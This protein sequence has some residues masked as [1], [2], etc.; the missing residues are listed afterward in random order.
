MLKVRH[1][2]DPILSKPAKPV[3]K[4]DAELLGLIKDMFETMYEEHG[5][6]LAAPQIGESLRLCVINCTENH[7]KSGE[8][9]LIN[10]KIIEMSGEEV[11][12]EG[13]L[14]VPGI[15]SK[16]ARAAHVKVK[17]FDVKGNEFE[18]EGD[19]LLAR[20]FQHEIDH[21]DGKL[22]IERLGFASRLV[23]RPRL[24]ELERR[25]KLE[26]EKK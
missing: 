7:D 5:V 1:Y 20:A 16:V 15:R 11:D 19:G 17:A 23:A 14:S 4:I 18:G 10:P 12:E 6:G 26:N 25:S 21:L 9:V 2:P 3:K 8:I 13:C 22:F 24:K